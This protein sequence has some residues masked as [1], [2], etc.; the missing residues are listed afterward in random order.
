MCVCTHLM[1]IWLHLMTSYHSWRHRAG[2]GP[3]SPA[4]R[5]GSDGLKRFCGYPTLPIL[6]DPFFVHYCIFSLPLTPSLSLSLPLSL[7]PSFSPSLLP[8]PS[9][10]PS[11]FFL[12]LLPSSLLLSSSSSSSPPSYRRGIIVYI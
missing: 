12:S 7:P 4:L 3:D 8:S 2:D 5:T 11:P 6:P 9:L 10:P 1:T